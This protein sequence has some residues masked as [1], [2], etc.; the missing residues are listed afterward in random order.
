MPP[1][2]LAADDYS[3]S[4]LPIKPIPGSY[5]LPFF[6]PIRDR[7]DFYYFQGHDAF[8]KSR[9]SK[10][11]STVFRVNVPP[12][13]S[14]A[15][16]PRVIAVLDA[17]SFPVL[18]DLSVVDKT[19][20]LTGTYIPSA[21]LTG[22]FRPLAYL[23]PADPRHAA[24][25]QLLFDL[26]AAR[27]PR[28]IPSFRA[29]Y[30]ALLDSLEAALAN[31]GPADFNT[32]NE[33]TALNFVCEFLFGGAAPSTTAHKKA[34]KWLFFQLHPLV[35]LGLP[36]LLEELF[37]HTFHLPPFLVRSDYKALASYFAEAAKPV[38]DDA[39][40]TRGL[41]REETLHNLVFVAVFNA[42]GGIKLSFPRILR[43]LA[44]SGPELHAR[45]AREIRSVV[46]SEGGAVTVAGLERMELT[47]SVVWEL[48][49][50]DPPVEYQYAR[51]KKDLVIESHEAAF[52]VKKGEMIFGYQPVATRDERV[53]RKGGEFVA[54]RFV[55]EEGK[56]L[57]KYVYWSNGR[58]T[59]EAEV[60]NKQCPGKDV[61]VMMCRLLVVEFFLRYD[62]F[63]AEV[64]MLP[65][66]PKVTVTSITKASSLDQS[67]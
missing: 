38:L 6:S 31:S 55:G 53:F 22:G 33:A 60:G 4:G 14:M 7:L 39:E 36:K 30:S 15:S 62:S 16:D 48:L 59:E 11:Q 10:Y 49:R 42:Y 37:F 29:A 46:R 64:G 66:E 63:T 19:D 3:S 13:F 54:D 50:L 40:K 57:L 8:F 12:A 21:A 51:A 56:K 28:L 41:S 17:K 58:E 9:V 20:V 61:V 5:G 65:L 44:E 18:F 34:I 24:L 43:R 45:L 26:L 32:L 1:T 2:K 25:K 27:G 23:D 67:S 47:K 52:R 35:T